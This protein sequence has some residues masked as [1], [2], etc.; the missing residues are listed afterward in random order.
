MKH[1]LYIDRWYSNPKHIAQESIGNRTHYVDDDT[2]RYF[3]SRVLHAEVLAGGLLFGIVESYAVDHEN[4]TRAF[5]PVIFNL[6]GSVV[7]RPAMDEGFNSSARAAKDMYKA[8]ELLDAVALNREGLEHNKK[9]TDWE[10]GELVKAIN[11]VA[12]TLGDNQ[13]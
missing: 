5:R 13:Q 11:A 2:L 8:V 7:Y 1:P 6:F 4:I 12:E 10:H 9:M 3:H